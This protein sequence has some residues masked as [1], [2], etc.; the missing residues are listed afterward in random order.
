MGYNKKLSG[1]YAPER[2]SDEIVFQVPTLPRIEAVHSPE[3]STSSNS[4][5][6]AQ[7]RLCRSWARNLRRRQYLKRLEGSSAKLFASAAILSDRSR[8]TDLSSNLSYHGRTGRRS[9]FAKIWQVAKRRFKIYVYPFGQ[10][11]SEFQ[12]GIGSGFYPASN[13]FHNRVPLGIQEK[14]GR[15]TT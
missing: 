12:N 8:Q 1:R 14:P 9:R 2:E 15:K 10:F 7:R 4:S 5:N 3:P 11:Y 13:T 6:S